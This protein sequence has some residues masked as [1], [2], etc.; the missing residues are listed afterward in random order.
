MKTT[1]I[2]GKSRI[3]VKMDRQRLERV[4]GLFVE[5]VEESINH[6]VS[7]NDT[8]VSPDDMQVSVDKVAT[9]HTAAP[10]SNDTRI[11]AFRCPACTK[12]IF[13]RLDS[14][15]AAGDTVH[16]HCGT[17]MTVQQIRKAAGTCPGCGSDFWDIGVINQLDSIPC[18]TCR[19]SIDLVDAGDGRLEVWQ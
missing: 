2:A 18:R 3:T 11:Y 19:A 1:L 9:S 14:D 15:L 12:T 8:P 4:L 17:E 6:F 5:Q 16:C 7:E 13:Q 10:T